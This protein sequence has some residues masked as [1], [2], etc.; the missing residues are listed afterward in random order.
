MAGICEDTSVLVAHGAARLVD[1][2]GRHDMAIVGRGLVRLRS[3]VRR[4]KPTQEPLQARAHFRQILRSFA[5]SVAA[6]L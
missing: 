1:P 6:A 4:T 2:A 3:L 5:Q